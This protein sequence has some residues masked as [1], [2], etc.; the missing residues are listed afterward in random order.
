MIRNTYLEI[1]TKTLVKC[2]EKM[3]EKDDKYQE[4]SKENKAIAIIMATTMFIKKADKMLREER[5]EKQNER[6]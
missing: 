6:D 4:L 3:L 1:Y 2:V 5:K